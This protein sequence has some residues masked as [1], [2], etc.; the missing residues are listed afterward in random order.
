MM[1]EVEGASQTQIL[2]QKRLLEEMIPEG[3]VGCPEERGCRNSMCVSGCT[4]GSPSLPRGGAGVES[5]Q[6]R[7]RGSMGSKTL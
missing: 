7:W 1:G 3:C 5:R 6:A 4:A 2:G